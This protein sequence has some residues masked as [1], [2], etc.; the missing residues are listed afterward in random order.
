[1]DERE[2]SEESAL[3][4]A[5]A[6]A[7]DEVLG[8]EALARHEKQAQDRQ[9]DRELLKAKQEI[10]RQVL[11]FWDNERSEREQTMAGAVAAYVIDG[12]RTTLKALRSRLAIPDAINYR[13]RYQ[14]FQNTN[15]SQ[16][17]LQRIGQTLELARQVA[18]D[19]GA[20]EVQEPAG[21]ALAEFYEYVRRLEQVP[22]PEYDEDPAAE[23]TGAAFLEAALEAMDSSNEGFDV[24]RNA[25]MGAFAEEL[26]DD[27]VLEPFYADSPVQQAVRQLYAALVRSV[28]A[29][30]A[31]QRDQ[32]REVAGWHLLCRIEPAEGEL[33]K[34]DAKV[35]SKS[36][37][38]LADEVDRSFGVYRQIVEANGLFAA[39]PHGSAHFGGSRRG[40]CLGE[41]SSALSWDEA[42]D[43]QEGHNGDTVEQAVERMRAFNRERYWGVLD[44]DYQKHV[45]HFWYGFKKLMESTDALT[46]V[47]LRGLEGYFD[48]T[49]IDLQKQA[50][51][52]GGRMDEHQI[53]EFCENVRE[54]PHR[55]AAAE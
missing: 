11:D 14:A 9:R 7:L 27:A 38:A 37:R 20:V 24:V 16:K 13:E 44:D 43:V 50:I 53:E 23:R 41:G 29:A 35:D 25:V 10:V 51:A 28:E 8:D 26:H 18:E 6:E 39:F 42:T 36:V 34:R 52:L 40:W 4:R 22:V 31:A 49:A 54:L 2:L 21:I 33:A 32:A 12:R 30:Q 47:D 5:L 17:L 15:D 1:M 48:R 46:K 19:H 45:N 3:A 55:Q